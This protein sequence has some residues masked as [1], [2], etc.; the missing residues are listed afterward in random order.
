VG[1]DV[2]GRV[3]A[4]SPGSDGASPYQRRGPLQINLESTRDVRGRRQVRGEA[5]SLNMAIWIE[6]REIIR[7]RIVG[8]MLQGGAKLEAGSGGAS[9]YQGPSAARYFAKNFSIAS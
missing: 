6:R 7:T 8:V 1:G 4:E 3:Q 9:P 5:E 2:T